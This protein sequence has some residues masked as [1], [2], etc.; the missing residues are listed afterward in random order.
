MVMSGRCLWCV[1]LMSLC[2]GSA[3]QAQWNPED[4]AWL[5]EQIFR[6]ETGGDIERL[7]FW[8][9]AEEFP[10]L[11][12]G[13]FIW[14]P[15]EVD[16]PFEASFPALVEYLVAHDAPQPPEW[17]RAP[18]PPWP[19]RAAFL[20]AHATPAMAE[21]RQWLLATRAMQAAFIAERFDLRLRALLASLPEREAEQ[22]LRRYYPLMQTRSGR[23]ALIDYSHFKGFGDYPEERYDGLGWGVLQVLDT[24]IE[25]KGS[26]A[27]DPYCWIKPFM[28]A[29]QAVLLRRI[30][31]APPHRN[32][33]RW[34]AGWMKRIDRYG[35]AI[36]AA[37]RVACDIQ[38]ANQ[39]GESK[40]RL[41]K[42]KK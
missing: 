29:A 27:A 31:H 30:E 25:P 11:G 15:A 8:S 16:V 33:G 10:S 41:K 4:N 32:E 7:V 1:L 36:P 9:E 13:H 40:N 24:M 38:N 34:Q 19:D 23:F 21:L 2:L 37:Q 42:E 5:G 12:I 22:V 17:V 14:I 3:A 35:E 39:E 6:N 26:G 28:D 20:Q 18:H